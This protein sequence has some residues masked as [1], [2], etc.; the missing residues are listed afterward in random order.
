MKKI[1]LITT[2]LAVSISCVPTYNEYIPEVQVVSEIIEVNRT[3]AQSYAKVNEWLV[4]VLKDSQSVKEYYDKDEGLI[5]S[6][7]I[8]KERLG[9]IDD[10]YT[11]ITINTKDDRV[12]IYFKSLSNFYQPQKIKKKVNE[13]SSKDPIYFN[14]N[15]N[16][17]QSNS[18]TYL[19]RDFEKDVNKM[20]KELKLHLEN[21]DDLYF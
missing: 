5:V 8:I 13:F 9:R 14:N 3:E 16:S 17:T 12:R 11:L 19:P 21:E 4:E 15:E 2:I 10:F 1:L 7:L 6:K 18:I 20:I